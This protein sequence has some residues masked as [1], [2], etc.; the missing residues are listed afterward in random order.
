MK[1]KREEEREREREREW[2]KEREEVG[3]HEN[4]IFL[5]KKNEKKIDI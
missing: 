4:K 3:M 2:E 5:I 1:Q